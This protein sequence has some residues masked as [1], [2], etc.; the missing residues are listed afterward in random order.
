M[1][2]DVVALGELLID[3]TPIENRIYQS[4]PGGA[5]ANV[6]A[7]VTKQG[8]KTGF[9]G[10][11][12]KDSFGDFL[13][14]TLKDL[15]IDTI[16]LK[17][18][19]EASTT[20]AFVHLDEMGDRS[21]SFIRKPGADMLFCEGEILYSMID[22]CKIFH[23]GS[24]SMTDEPSRTATLAAAKYAKQN[25][26]LVSYDPNLRELLWTNLDE[27]RKV[28]LEGFKYADYVKIS[29]EEMEFLFGTDNLEKGAKIA[30]QTGVNILF[31][32]IGAK[33]CY[34]AHADIFGKFPTYSVK[35]IDTTGAGD[36]F[37][38]GVL[39]GILT[40]NI[41]REDI[42]NKATLEEIVNYANAMGALATTK[43]GG[44]SSMP[45]AEEVKT[46]I[47]KGSLA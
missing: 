12:G 1:K 22:N 16:G 10:K 29:E 7:A 14:K 46:C 15:N 28:I 6:L 24:V 17:K 43:K 37:M 5:P 40:K 23:F 33:G 2:Y 41:K 21:F 35:T 31:V 19:D 39:T 25:G 9:M 26:K 34:Y 42:L 27:A 20:L 47:E 44:I 32:T 3:F 18:T 11:V 36:S 45:T 8:F 4:N 38:G 13:E 30:L